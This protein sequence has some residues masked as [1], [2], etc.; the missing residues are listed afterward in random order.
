[1]ASNDP[2]DWE[3]AF[4]EAQIER[5]TAPYRDLLPPEALAE[6][7]EVLGDLLA[8]H[9]VPQRLLARL[10][11]RKEVTASG[12]VDAEGRPVAPAADDAKR[13]GSGA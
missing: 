13:G 10:K 6:M 11:P 5:A 1:M 9:P 7:A 4:I 12:D 8:T 2:D 3:D